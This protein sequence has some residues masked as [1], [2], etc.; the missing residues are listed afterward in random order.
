M[1]YF[2][3]P[4]IYKK[5]KEQ[6]LEMSQSIQI[7]YPERISPEKRRPG[8]SDEQIAEAIGIETS[9]VREIRCVAER[10][11]YSLDEWQRAIYFKDNACREYSVRGVSS[12][13][14]KY[15]KKK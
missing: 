10:E 4:K 6:V 2:I 12:V 7:N 3:D 11:Y 9:I 14:K 15:L 1:N 5:Y 8:F 13:T